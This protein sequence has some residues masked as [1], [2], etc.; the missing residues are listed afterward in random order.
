[1][2]E[3]SEPRTTER[4]EPALTNL[5]K[6]IWSEILSIP[7]SSTLRSTTATT[8]TTTSTTTTTT[9][10]TTT[11]ISTTTATSINNEEN[12]I[13]IVE[14]SGAVQDEDVVG[15]GD[16]IDKIDNDEV[17]EKLVEDDDFFKDS[18]DNMEMKDDQSEE[19]EAETIAPEILDDQDESSGE[20]E[21]IITLPKFESSNLNNN[22]GGSFRITRPK[23]PIFNTG[24]EVFKALIDLILP[25]KEAQSLDSLDDDNI[26]FKQI[27]NFLGS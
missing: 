9:I 13:E 12:K 20:V 18:A 25:T 2:T 22:D 27:F 14:G 7:S 21:L 24:E 5:I 3:S 23:E 16:E 17:M 26:S 15:S 6:D 11:K 8:T 4:T 1:M 10:I 19:L